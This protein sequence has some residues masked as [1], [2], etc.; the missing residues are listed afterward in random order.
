MAYLLLKQ[1]F[2]HT[3]NMHAYRFYITANILHNFTNFNMNI[4]FMYNFL[5][6]LKHKFTC[7]YV[8]VELKTYSLEYHL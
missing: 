4:T 1:D 5:Y 6:I 2:K 7:M 8:S 3:L